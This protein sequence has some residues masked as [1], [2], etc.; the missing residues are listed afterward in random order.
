[1]NIFNNHIKSVPVTFFINKNFEE[2][3]KI[4]IKNEELYIEYFEE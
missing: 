4:S 3:L 2:G 1:M